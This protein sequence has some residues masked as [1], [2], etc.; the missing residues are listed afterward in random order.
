MIP[1]NKPFRTVK[2]LKEFL[3]KLDPTIE[4]IGTWEGCVRD[5][6]AYFDAQGNLIIDLDDCNYQHEHQNLKCH[7]CEKQAKTI[8]KNRNPACFSHINC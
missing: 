7:M 8:D 4:L 6:F 1:K 2:E 5:I 3:E